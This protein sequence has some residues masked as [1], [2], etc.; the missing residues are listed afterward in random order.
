[1]ARQAKNTEEAP[2]K[3]VKNAKAAK[4]PAKEAKEEKPVKGGKAAA[5]D[6]PAKEAA[7]KA[8]KKE[9][10]PKELK[11]LAAEAAVA[12]N[13]EQIRY[14]RV[15]KHLVNNI[16]PELNQS[17]EDFNKKNE[18]VLNDAKINGLDEGVTSKYLSAMRLPTPDYKKDATPEQRGKIFEKAQKEH[19]EAIK[20][21]ADKDPVFKSFVKQY[22][23]KQERRELL[24]NKVHFGKPAFVGTGAMLDEVSKSIITFGCE[25]AKAAER[26]RVDPE[27][28]LSTGIEKTPLYALFGLSN[29]FN[30]TFNQVLKEQAAKEAKANKDKDAKEVEEAEEADEADDEDGPSFEYYVNRV[31]KNIL[32][33]DAKFAGM[34]VSKKTRLFVAD[35]VADIVRN[36]AGSLREIL[37]VRKAKTIKYDLIRATVSSVMK[38]HGQDAT[39]LLKSMDD[40]VA[41]WQANET[42]KAE[43]R[44]AEAK[45]NAGKAAK[46]AKAAAKGKAAAADDESSSS[47]SSE[48]ESSDE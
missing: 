35:I 2:A 16:D 41:G 9:K 39:A 38:F 31:G 15:K 13:S 4:A 7:K 27:H 5:K 42:K 23:V 22:D 25:T 14:A 34:S 19:R 1:M 43:A 28:C 36:F 18:K 21:Q 3:E 40:R 47:S 32:T 24:R 33:A 29:A 20:K 30:K 37:T 44:L 6:A 10:T 8:P 11:A 45:A 26:R 12:L 48:S 17:L 46:P